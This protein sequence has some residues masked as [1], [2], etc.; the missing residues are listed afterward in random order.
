MIKPAEEKIT[1]CMYMN[2]YTLKV[3]LSTRCLPLTILMG[4]FLDLNYTHIKGPS[5]QRESADDNLI[6]RNYFLVAHK[7]QK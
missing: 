7:L 4:L 3:G 5:T 6:V 1:T 2:A